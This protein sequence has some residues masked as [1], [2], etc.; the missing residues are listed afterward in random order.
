LPNFVG[1][2]L[3]PF[4]Q[5]DAIHSVDCTVAAWP[6]VHQTFCTVG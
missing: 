6:S 3:F 2:Q 4:L 1:I 5:H